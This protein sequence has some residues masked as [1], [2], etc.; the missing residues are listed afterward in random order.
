[1]SFQV[2]GSTF[3][4]FPSFSFTGKI[5]SDV[6]HRHSFLQGQAP[7]RV[8]S[9][10][11]GGGDNAIYQA[12]DSTTAT[13]DPTSHVVQLYGD[14]TRSPAPFTQKRSGLQ[15]TALSPYN[16]T[17][18]NQR[19]VTSYVVGN[20]L[21]YNTE[22]TTIQQAI[23][24][25][26]ADG[27]DVN[28][29]PSRQVQ[30][31]I[32]PGDYPDDAVVPRHGISLLGLTN[33]YDRSVRIGGILTVAP[34]DAANKTLIN[35]RNLTFE[36]T[37]GGNPSNVGLRLVS[38]VNFNPK[39]MMENVYMF[40][41]D[42]SLEGLTAPVEMTF[43]TSL[44]GN[45]AFVQA[46]NLEARQTVI[47]G[48]V[49]V[50]NDGAS[51]GSISLVNSQA[52]VLTDDFLPSALS[53]YADHSTLYVRSHQTNPNSL[54]P[55]V[56]FC[57]A[58]FSTVLLELGAL[59]DPNNPLNQQTNLRLRQCYGSVSLGTQAALVPLGKI[60]LENC[61]LDQL[62]LLTTASSAS[63][64][65]IL[66]LKNC[67]FIRDSSSLSQVR[68]Q[69]F[70]VSP[71]GPNPPITVDFFACQFGALVVLDGLNLKVWDIQ[72]IH[73]IAQY[74]GGSPA[75]SVHAVE[76]GATLVSSG[77]VYR[78]RDASLDRVVSTST[79]AT[80]IRSPATSGGFP[81]NSF[82]NVILNSGTG[83]TQYIAGAVAVLQ[84]GDGIII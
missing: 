74:Q 41:K 81:S 54:S 38:T 16:V 6:A 45:V 47:Q 13:Q 58:S 17:M 21:V 42:V 25:A 53:V 35:I 64:F 55:R 15:T 67:A 32:K 61:A 71:F 46:A 40:G 27:V 60:D 83:P 1:M 19:D 50:S 69:D 84:E 11:G 57:A 30:I 37:P 34:T 65:T 44:I 72:S 49:L 63:D 29:V 5:P 52:S 66:S 31:L 2:P 62:A 9:G 26:V 51:T 22:F 28:A 77:C 79:T 59:A 82:V 43:L 78:L 24:Q 20:P 39:C 3:V 4:A 14:T 56:A 73:D 76:N 8:I 33:G 7:M 18:E 75:L 68:L 70:S 23:D 10:G 80:W 12:N 36:P 48:Q